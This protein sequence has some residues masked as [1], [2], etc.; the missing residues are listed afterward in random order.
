M[1]KPSKKAKLDKLAVEN[2]TS[3]PAEDPEAANPLEE[4]NEVPHDD[5]S[6]MDREDLA[7]PGD[8]PMENPA[9]PASPIRTSPARVSPAPASP[10]H[11]HPATAADPPRPTAAP[12]DDVEITGIGFTT[13]AEPVI[14]ARHTAK[15]EVLQKDKGKWSTDMSS[16]APLSA[17]ELHSG[18]L[19][20]L[21]ANRDHEAG[22]VN[23][24]KE[25][26]EVTY[27]PLPSISACILW[28]YR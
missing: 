6:P 13:P 4:N 19:N 22:L 9:E 16:Y 24:M 23:L 3:E 5:P 15:E 14:L 12:T 21:F 26:Y 8:D 11:N 1:P 17:Q 25:K 27:F 28:L 20:R 2:T 10:V 18:Y 7:A